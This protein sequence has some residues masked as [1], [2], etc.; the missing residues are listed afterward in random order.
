MEKFEILKIPSNSLVGRSVSIKITP[1]LQTSSIYSKLF[2]QQTALTPWW[3]P[4][5]LRSR[6][7]S[8]RSSGT[9]SRARLSSWSICGS[10][11][12]YWWNKKCPVMELRIACCRNTPVT[13]FVPGRAWKRTYMVGYFK[14]H[15]LWSSRVG[16]NIFVQIDLY[17]WLY[18][19][20]L[21]MIGAG[22]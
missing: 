5:F 22:K 7:T 9:G 16:F 6:N 15:F 18:N 20:P 1:N 17:A 19:K 21:F 3:N 11:E 8:R 14:W 4:I 12:F 2:K 13:P 10:S